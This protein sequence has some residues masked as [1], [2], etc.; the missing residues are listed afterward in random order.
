[1]TSGGPGLVHCTFVCHHAEHALDVAFSESSVDLIYR[2]KILVTFDHQQKPFDVATAP[3]PYVAIRT[4]PSPYFNKLPL[5]GAGRDSL[6]FDRGPRH[7]HPAG[8]T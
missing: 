8:S 5:M 4:R 1:M 7:T 2:L 6:A 3:L